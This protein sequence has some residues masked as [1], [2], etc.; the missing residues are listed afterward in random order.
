MVIDYYKEI[1]ITGEI[2]I[3]FKISIIVEHLMRL[4]GMGGWVGLLS[5]DRDVEGSKHLP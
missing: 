1:K 4:S 3:D 2:L 5:Y